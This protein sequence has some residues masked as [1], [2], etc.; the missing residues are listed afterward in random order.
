M[1]GRIELLLLLEKMEMEFEVKLGWLE[2]RA[3]ASGVVVG[4]WEDTLVERQGCAGDKVTTEKSVSSSEGILQ[5][6]W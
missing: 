6:G 5:M 3:D 1:V 2:A 4:G